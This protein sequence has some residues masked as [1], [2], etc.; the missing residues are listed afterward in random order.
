MPA[1]RD[2]LRPKRFRVTKEQRAFW[3]G[4]LGPLIVAVCGWI[5]AHAHKVEAEAERTKRFELADGFQEYIEYVMKQR[6]CE[7]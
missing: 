2:A 4:V 6:G 1:R 5:N 7:P 3:L